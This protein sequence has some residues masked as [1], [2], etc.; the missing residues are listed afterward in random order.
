MPTPRRLTGYCYACGLRRDLVPATFKCRDRCHPYGSERDRCEGCGTFAALTAAGPHG[1][2]YCDAPDDHCL[3]ANECMHFRPQFHHP[4]EGR[5]GASWIMARRHYDQSAA[6]ADRFDFIVVPR[7]DQCLYHW[8]R[9]ALW[10]RFGALV[11]LFPGFPEG[12]VPLDPDNNPPDLHAV[13]AHLLDLYNRGF[14]DRMRPGAKVVL[15]GLETVPHVPGLPF[16]VRNRLRA[17]KETLSRDGGAMAGATWAQ[18]NQNPGA[19]ALALV[20]LIDRLR[21]MM[22]SNNCLG[23]GAVIIK[24]EN[25]NARRERRFRLSLHSS[26][27][28][29]LQH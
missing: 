28:P 12:A 27:A 5:D 10:R 11:G 25:S 1:Y 3:F 2:W 9:V 15:I 24:D 4:L 6:P 14:F 21:R 23:L 20:P 29:Q 22:F 8:S 17:F 7:T 19:A 18:L 13:G 26:T 16:A